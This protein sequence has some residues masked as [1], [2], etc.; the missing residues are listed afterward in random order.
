MALEKRLEKYG[1][2]EYIYCSGMRYAGVENLVS[3]EKA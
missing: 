3:E 2:C 1:V